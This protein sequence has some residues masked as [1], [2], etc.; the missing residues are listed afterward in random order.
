MTEKKDNINIEKQLTKLDKQVRNLNIKTEMLGK[1]EVVGIRNVVQN[2]KAFTTQQGKYI[3]LTPA[4]SK[5]SVA[6]I[7]WGTW[8]HML[9]FDT[10]VKLGYVVRDDSFLGPYDN[11]ASR[12]EI[13]I[14]NAALDDEIMEKFKLPVVDI[15]EWL[16][17]I[18]SEATVE[19]ILVKAQSLKKDDPKM[20]QVIE[21]CERK[22]VILGIAL[23]ADFDEMNLDS[24][25]I[26]AQERKLDPS[27]VLGEDE[28]GLRE[29][30]VE[31]LA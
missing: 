10:A 23:P 6:I 7:D 18:D 31:A 27:I 28:V 5:N 26:L 25:K 16:K 4:G 12:D 14:P 13:S 8:Q 17:S 24:L 21:L 29:K 1:S 3:R 2:T 9:Q 30:I 15:K 20:Y 19:R 11:P 22:Q